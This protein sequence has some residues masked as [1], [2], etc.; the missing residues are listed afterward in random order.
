MKAASLMIVAKFCG[1]RGPNSCISEVACSQ[2]PSVNNDTKLKSLKLF[3]F[4]LNGKCPADFVIE[5]CW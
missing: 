2:L 3:V 1:A 4:I 5:S